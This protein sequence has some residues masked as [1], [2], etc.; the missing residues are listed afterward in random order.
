M[1]NGSVFVV[2]TINKDFRLIN[3]PIIMAEG[4]AEIIEGDNPENYIKN[5][6]KEDIQSYYKTKKFDKSYIK[7]S[8]TNSLKRIIKTQ[9]LKKPIVR[10]EL[11]FIK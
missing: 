7:E 8:M 3:E 11:N 4:L 10:L 2:L 9:Y 5:F 1:F 6:I